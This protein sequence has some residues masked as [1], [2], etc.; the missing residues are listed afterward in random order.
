MVINQYLQTIIGVRKCPCVGLY[1]VKPSCY[2]S[3]ILNNDIY[4]H[5]EVC[6]EFIFLI[7]LTSLK[8]HLPF[9]GKLVHVGTVV[10]FA[11][12]AIVEEIAVFSI[13]IAASDEGSIRRFEFKKGLNA[14]KFTRTATEAETLSS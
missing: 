9:I 2:R 4:S 13:S 1:S 8:I 10:L 11:G 5:T 6:F 7:S 14:S 12:P 3:N